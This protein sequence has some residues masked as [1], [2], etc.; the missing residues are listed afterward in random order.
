MIAA[1]ILN[2]AFRVSC[3]HAGLHYAHVALKLHHMACSCSAPIQTVMHD[4]HVS[5]IVMT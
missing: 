1:L 2:Y 3:A 5:A 4:C